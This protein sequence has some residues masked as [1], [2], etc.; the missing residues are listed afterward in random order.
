MSTLLMLQ[1]GNLP[2]D[3]AV[4]M[5]K[6]RDGTQKRRIRC[7]RCGWQPD[8]SS[9]WCCADTGAP[10]HFAPGCGTSWNTFDTRG[11]CPG[12]DHQWRW[13]LCLSC[14]GWGRHEDWYADEEDES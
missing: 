2:I 7:P 14:H 12:C 1:R 4:I 11:L 13:T 6:L 10:E 9:Q 3:I 5:Q 8:R